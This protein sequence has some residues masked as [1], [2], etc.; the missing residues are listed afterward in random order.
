MRYLSRALLAGGAGF[1][2]SFLAACGGGAG[3][4]SGDQASGLNN[5]LNKVSQA[6]ASGNCGAV[7]DGAEAFAVQVAN[8]P[9][10]VSATLRTD[11]DQGASAISTA[12]VRQCQQPT[13][14][15]APPA[16]T[17]TS[18]T[19]TTTTTHTTTTTTTPTT[20]TSTTTTPTTPATTPTTTGTTGTG[21]SGGGGLGG[22]VGGGSGAG[23]TGGAGGGPLGGGA[24]G[25][26][27]NNG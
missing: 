20:T 6:L 13:T 27:G 18:T 1:A 19:P 2:V 21:S 4:L 24:N 9:A 22:G 11:L 10:T 25:G 15:T 26:N 8:L 7:R 14:R 17:T 12:A 3:L 5:Q 23:G 16:T